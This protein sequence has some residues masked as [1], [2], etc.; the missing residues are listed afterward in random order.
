MADVVNFPAKYTSYLVE[1]VPYRGSPRITW[2][3]QVAA[4]K[5]D[6]FLEELFSAKQESAYWF[7]VVGVLPDGKKEVVRGDAGSPPDGCSYVMRH[8]GI[9][10]P[11]SK[12]ASLIIEATTRHVKERKKKIGEEILRRKN[13]IEG[14][15]LTTTSAQPPAKVVEPPVINYDDFPKVGEVV[16]KIEVFQ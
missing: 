16:P 10:S 7:Q 13:V 3:M 12:L 9:I 6:D 14:K 5:L 8:S 1:Y 11:G 15:P 4:D 2:P